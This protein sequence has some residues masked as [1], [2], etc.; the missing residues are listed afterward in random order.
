MPDEDLVVMLSQIR[1]TLADPDEGQRR[2]LG[3]MVIGPLGKRLDDSVLDGKPARNRRRLEPSGNL[4]GNR[5]RHHPTSLSTRVPAALLALEAPVVH[6]TTPV[7]SPMSNHSRDHPS[8][9]VVTG[10]EG[11]VDSIGSWRAALRSRCRQ[12]S[13]AAVGPFGD[14]FVSVLFV[15]FTQIASPGVSHPSEREPVGAFGTVREL[16]RDDTQQIAEV[17]DSGVG[18]AGDVVQDGGLAD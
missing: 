9:F 8:D 11:S 13:V 3:S 5:E 10:R 12:R 7:A 1:P 14:Q 18:S 16:G 15:M 2:Q 6:A 4:V 17:E